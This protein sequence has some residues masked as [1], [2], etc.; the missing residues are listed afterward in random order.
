MTA[1]RFRPHRFGIVGLYEYADQEFA[2]EDGRLALR[3]RNTSGKS[4]ALEL[5]IPYVLDGDITPRKLDPFASS[6]KT[7][8][9]NLIECTDAQDRVTKRIGY[10]WAEFRAVDEEG[11]ERFLSCGLGLEA[12]R[13]ADGIKDRWY[14]TTPLRIG[15]GLELTRLIGDGDT[16]PVVKSDLVEQLGSDGTFYGGPREYKEALRAQLLPF[17]TAELYE[18]MLE[19]IR[20]LR[21]PKLSDSLNVKGLSAMLSGALPGVDDAL[22]RKLGDALEQLHELQRQH[23]ELRDARAEV[24]ALVDGEGRSYARGVLA[25]RGE[26]LK[27]AVG[28][29]DRARAAA[30]AREDE[31]QAAEVALGAAD[32]MAANVADDHRRVT[33]EHLAL[34]SSEA[35]KAVGLLEARTREHEQAMQRAKRARATTQRLAAQVEQAQTAVEQAQAEATTA[36]ATLSAV[37]ERLAV[38]LGCAGLDCPS[39]QTGAA[40]DALAGRLAVRASDLARA[41]ELLAVL[42]AAEGLLR[43]IADPLALASTRRDAAAEAVAASEAL[44]ESAV[45][46]YDESLHAWRLSLRELPIEDAQLELLA[47][48]AVEDR[49]PRTLL[50]DFVAARGDEL[51]ARQ[52]TLTNAREIAREEWSSAVARVREIAEQ[53]DPAPPRLHPRRASRAGR[54]GAPLWAV[55]DFAEGLPAEQRPQLEAALEDAGILDAWIA[56]DGAIHDADVT[57]LAPASPGPAVPSLAD[58]LIADPGDRAIDGGVVRAVLQSIALDGPLSVAPGRFRFGPVHGRADKPAAEFIGAAARAARRERLLAEAK[59]VAR[60]AEQRLL[61]LEAELERVLAARKQLDAERQSLPD[62]AA[63]RSALRAQRQT[64]DRLVAHEEQLAELLAQRERYDRDVTEARETLRSHAHATQLPTAP[65]SC[66]RWL[67]RSSTRRSG[68][69]GSSR[70]LLSSPPPTDASSTRSAALRAP[71]RSAVPPKTT[72]APPA[73]TSSRPRDVSR[74]RRRPRAR[75]SPNCALAQPASAPSSSASIMPGRR[76]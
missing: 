76:P 40:L 13:S 54:A 9:W 43:A 26:R 25:V 29:Y 71:R 5:L 12:T 56:P 30:R 63:L 4:K 15:A 33:E 62:P 1:T 49:D 2:V 60:E 17:A 20:Q 42:A 11:G 57:L 69:S 8:R 66:A 46:Q 51:A 58:V 64:A 52:A 50:T 38:Q 70:R 37:G 47:T 55:C 7:M 16:Q 28:A 41:D 74:P 72:S 68:S 73:R 18:Q 24:S 36:Q 22:V 3:G 53:E 44:L 67:R 21:K 31:Y 61:A 34:V 39:L 23:D 35:Y 19:I 6:D 48:A 75:R 32:A 59:A 45:E 10:V 14:F 27:A 65:Q